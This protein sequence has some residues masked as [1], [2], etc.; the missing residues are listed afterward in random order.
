MIK[1]QL[2]KLYYLFANRLNCAHR[3]SLSASLG[4]FIAFCPLVGLHTVIAIFCGWL[5]SL[6]T[7]VLLV[8]SMT[9]N[10]PWTMLGVYGSGHWFGISMC[11]FF[12]IDHMLFAPEYL[13]SWSQWLFSFLGTSQFSIG[14]FLIGGN[15]L[16]LLCAFISYPIIKYGIIRY[17]RYKTRYRQKDENSCSQ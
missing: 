1:Q 2:T 16:G 14:A 15:A 4:V 10:N 17:I 6:H 8:V 13:Q 3:L 12:A 7:S 11:D 9:I 5:F